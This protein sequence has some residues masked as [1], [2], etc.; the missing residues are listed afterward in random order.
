HTLYMACATSLCSLL[1]LPISPRTTNVTTGRV[2]SRGCRCGP[3][4]CGAIGCNQPMD[5]PTTR[6]PNTALQKP[7]TFMVFPRRTGA[8]GPGATASVSTCD[9]LFT[10]QTCCAWALAHCSR[11][12]LHLGR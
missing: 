8:Q 3:R 11:R 4:T 6:T 5:T 12:A 10:P 2:G 1:P 9:E 7:D